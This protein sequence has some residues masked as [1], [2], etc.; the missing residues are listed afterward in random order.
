MPEPDVHEGL[1]LSP[2]PQP[3]CLTLVEG[4]GHEGAAG[5]GE[6]AEEGGDE[7]HEE[8][9]GE[10][11]PQALDQLYHEA[12]LLQAV[13]EDGDQADGEED[14]IG[15]VVGEGEASHIQEALEGEARGEAEDEGG[16][17]EGETHVDPLQR[18]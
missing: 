8:S 14:L 18:Q 1:L 12:R 10:I 9:T 17:E 7:G 15:R 5:H 6:E 16:E 13:P 4:G 2:Q 11:P 3:V